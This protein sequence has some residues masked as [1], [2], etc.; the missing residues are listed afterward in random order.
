MP[1]PTADLVDLPVGS[2]LCRFFADVYGGD[3]PQLQRDYRA[4]GVRAHAD[5]LG[6]LRVAAEMGDVVRHFGSLERLLR[7]ERAASPWLRDTGISAVCQYDARR[8]TA[9]ELCAVAGQHT[10]T[11]PGETPLPIAGFYADLRG[12]RIVGEVDISNVEM[13]VDVLAAR[14]RVRDRVE[15]DLA[16]LEFLDLR[17]MR[18]FVELVAERDGLEL[19][20][21]NASP[22]VQRS[23]VLAGLQ[24]PRLVIS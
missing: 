10:A 17:A 19:L 12:V 24:H 9:E 14:A 11:T 22:Q 23:F 15:V 18:A 3:L 21:R 16:E 20:L 5:G 7:W 8:F 1:L 13:L 2:H 6:G 4:L